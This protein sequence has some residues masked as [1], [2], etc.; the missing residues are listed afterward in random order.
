VVTLTVPEMPTD[1]TP[2]VE[3][4]GAVSDIAGNELTEGD[5]TASDGVGP[6]VAI[7]VSPDPCGAGDATFDLTFSEAMKTSVDPTVEFTRDGGTETV[8]GDW[9]GTT[10]WQGTFDISGLD[11]QE[12]E[13]VVTV[14]L[15]EDLAANVMAE[16]TGSFNIDTLVGTPTFS[17]A[18]EAT[19]Y[20]ASPLVRIV[21]S[22]EVTITEATFGGEDVLV[23]LNTTDNKTFK[24][25]TEDLAAG[26]YTI[27]VS[28]ED[29]L[30]N[31]GGPFEATFTVA[32]ALSYDIE[33]NAGWNLI[34]L[35]LVPDDTSIDAVLSGLSVPGSVSKIWA[36]DAQT[37]SWSYYVPS[38]GVGELSVMRD[39]VGY[40]VEM[41]ADTTLTIHGSVLPEPP[42]PPQSYNVYAGW[43]LIGCT[44][45]TSPIADEAYL[46]SV[47]IDYTHIWGYDASTDYF[48]VY[49]D[50]GAGGIGTGQMEAGMGYW[51]WMT[52]DGVIVPSLL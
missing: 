4:V 44:T 38:S 1:A 9:T 15:G 48:V 27:S 21:F 28:A 49:P 29:A 25:T 51:I 2:T 41:S 19:I 40:F 12:F 42:S 10:T 33:L 26:E 14:T 20:T 23:D 17:P 34:S 16:A 24:L 35:P 13:S 36:Y 46:A 6:T 5:V 8:T 52:A 11:G 50:A 30:G 47:A 7:A 18:D 3:L 22:E 37:K 43:N 32:A 39:G 45:Q 31:T